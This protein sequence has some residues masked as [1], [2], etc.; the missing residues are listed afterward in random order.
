MYLNGSFVSNS[1]KP[2]DFDACW[3]TTGV[4]WDRIDPVFLTF[5]DLRREQK[6]Q[7]L[8]EFFSADASADLYGTTYLEF[9]QI[10]EWTERS[11]GIIAISLEDK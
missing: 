4:D 2:N 5:D 8:G 9:F 1:S 11:K 3:D 7:F 6:A 10:D